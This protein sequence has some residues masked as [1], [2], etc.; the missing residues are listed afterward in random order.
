MKNRFLSTFWL[1]LLLN[2]VLQGAVYADETLTLLFTNDTHNRLEPYEHVELKKRVGGI[3]RRQHY[4]DQVRRLNPQTLILDAGDVFQGT[5]YYNFYLGEPDIQAMGLMGYHA[6]TVGNH[7]LD[8]GLANLKKQTAPAPFPVLNANIVDARTGELIF[9]PYHLFEVDG[10]KIAVMGLMSDHA[11]Q[12]VAT[13][14][15]Q[16]LKLLDPVQV[17]NQLVP[18]LRAQA[19]L[20]ISLHHMGIWIDEEF[21]KQV[22]GVDVII[23]G[24][25]HTLMEKAKVLPNQNQNGLRGTLLQH[26][27]YMGAYVGR[28]DLTLD[29]QRKIVKHDSQL[30]LLDERFDVDPVAE[31]LD[32]YGNKLKAQMNEVIGESLDDMGTDGKYNGPFALGSLVADIIRGSQKVD[33]GIINT[34]GIRTSL[35]KGPITVGEIFEIMPFDNAL[36]NFAIKGKDLR[37]VVETS[38]SRLGVSKNLQFSGLV[39]SLKN[40]QVTDIRVNGQLI[41]PERL[42]SAS[43]PDYVFTGNEGIS[44]ESASQV[45]PTGQLIR[46]ILLNY[47]RQK[48]QIKAPT[49]QRLIRLGLGDRYPSQSIAWVLR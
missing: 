23:G 41:E 2:V 33:V 48:R 4:F 19:D 46:D 42:Y 35:N 26:A 10:I 47:V 7:D 14:N 13:A 36:T 6:M 9:K 44:F 22:P 21:P 32:R 25:S 24:H 15:K 39:Y 8:N 28:I 18:K 30:V 12:A 20:I 31:M 3:V 27:Y 17:A 38:A 29:K 45:Q 34:G 16:G 37:K 11:W 1:V 40:N 43:A 5:P 49:D